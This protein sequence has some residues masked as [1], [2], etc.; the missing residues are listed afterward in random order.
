MRESLRPWEIHQGLLW[1]WKPSWAPAG[2]PWHDPLS[3][4][5]ASFYHQ[6]I[7]FL[8]DDD[9]FSKLRP[10]P[11]YFAFYKGVHSYVQFCQSY[12]KE[13]L[14]SCPKGTTSTVVGL[15]VCSS[16]ATGHFTL[17]SFFTFFKKILFIYYGSAGPSLL[18]KLFSS[19]S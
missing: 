5:T 19:C 14:R 7:V 18:C 10:S 17:P 8:M 3:C 9:G 13:F 2:F 16:L 11:D 1:P 4:Y 6:Q 12:V 15:F